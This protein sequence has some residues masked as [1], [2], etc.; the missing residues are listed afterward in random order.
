MTKQQK[1]K[2]LAYA[3]VVFI[4]LVLFVAAGIFS[5]AGHTVAYAA[6]SDVNYDYTAIEDDLSG[7]DLSGYPANPEGSVRLIEL[8]EYCY[9]DNPFRCVN[10]GLYLYVY[11]PQLLSVSHAANA[12]SVNIATEYDDEGKPVTYANKAI[13]YLDSTDNGLFYKF[14]IADPTDI[15]SDAREYNGEYG[16]R[17]YDIAGIQLRETGSQTST[18][19]TVGGS[20]RFSG[21]AAGYGG[22][23]AESTLTCDVIELETLELDVHHTFYRPEGNNRLPIESD[24][25]TDNF[26]DQLN[27]VYFTVPNDVLDRYGDFSSIHAEWNEYRTKPIW[28]TANTT[29]YDHLADYIGH[30]VVGEYD[31][32]VR[33]GFASD[34]YNVGSSIV[35]GVLADLTYMD[36]AYNLNISSDKRGHVGVRDGFVSE[37][38]YLFLATTES[39]G[40]FTVTGESLKNYML[41]YSADAAD[42]DLICGKYAK[43]LFTEDVG[44]GRTAGYNNVSISSDYEFSLTSVNDQSFW[45]KFLGIYDVDIYTG[46]KAIYA[47]GDSDFKQ[48]TT[49]TCEGLYINES[50]YTEFR[51]LYDAAK[52]NDE[53]LFLFRFAVTDYYGAQVAEFDGTV[54]DAVTSA[55]YIDNNAYMAM[56]NVFLDFDVIDTTFSRDGVYTVIPVVSDPIDVIGDVTPPTDFGEGGCSGFAWWIIPVII[57]GVL[58]LILLI[59]LMPAI[60]IGIGK[61]L[62][63]I[64]SLPFRLGKKIAK[65]IRKSKAAKA[66]KQ[67]K[68]TKPSNA[69]KATKAPKTVKGSGGSARSGTRNKR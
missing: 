43:D 36:Y 54:N 22:S 59:P 64:L 30:T 48:N 56:Q 35:G 32:S 15:L 24:G 21:Y 6:A 25:G 17:R 41:Q 12:N 16:E 11:N 61:L 55:D 8:A 51:A 29:V 46:I 37:L 31:G 1:K 53:T 62:L 47:V 26:Q 60:L 28:V 65:K 18:D 2:R 39:A 14:K 67:P 57:L 23:N 42:E 63:F 40:D 5:S 44:E 20:Y 50:D 58:F 34:Y 27:S 4:W 49:E 52:E 13:V 68:S 45:E 19:Y 10:Y 66:P 9:S 69:H 7:F 38:Y 3:G 33:Y